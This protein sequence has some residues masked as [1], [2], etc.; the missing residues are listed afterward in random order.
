MATTTFFPTAA[1]FLPKNR[2]ITS[3]R[4]AAAVCKGCDLYRHA[5][6]TVFGEGKLKPQM[7]LIGEQ[8]GDAEDLQG[9]PFVG[10]A[11]KLLDK[12]LIAAG[13]AREDIYVTNA[14]KHFKFE[15]RGKKRLHSKPSA[16]EVTACKPWLVAEL[17]ATNPAIIVCLGATAAQSL[18]GPKFRITKDRGTVVES[19]E[20]WRC[21][22]TYHPSALLRLPDRSQF[23]PMFDTLVGDLKKAASMKHRV[24]PTV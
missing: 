4:K 24:A 8:P 2:S 10:P 14:V 3:L 20:G 23:Q 13:I 21:L 12:A 17:L 18:L 19:P 9:H 22:A 16:R 1:P 6:Q 11:G 5:T 15:P 7:V